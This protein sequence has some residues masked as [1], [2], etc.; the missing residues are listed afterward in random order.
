VTTERSRRGLRG[1]GA[2]LRRR[3]AELRDEVQVVALAAR[4]PRTGRL[5]KVVVGLVVAYVLSPIDPI[6]DVLPVLGLLDELVVVPLGLALAIRLIPPAALTHARD[7]HAAGQRVA[8]RLGI[9]VVAVLWLA[10]AV[11]GLL[12]IRALR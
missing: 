10:A 7:R 5:P 8:T 11:G 3:A 9:A 6:P 1:I 4:D 2:G 12:A